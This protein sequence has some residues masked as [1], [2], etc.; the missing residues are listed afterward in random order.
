MIETA[1]QIKAK[2]IPA[3]AY[4]VDYVGLDLTLDGFAVESVTG[5]AGA[6]AAAVKTVVGISQRPL[7]LMSSDPD[8]IAAGLA[9]TNGQT[10]LIYAADEDNWEAMAG[11]AKEHKAAL[12]VSG[13]SL[14]RLADLT[15]KIQGKGV[16][17]MVLE[18]AAAII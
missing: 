7:I 8:V 2:L 17:D 16:E 5:D 13:S 11:L 6:F 3:E 4:H 1:E 12:V 10:P 18:P 14:D 15:E 9:A